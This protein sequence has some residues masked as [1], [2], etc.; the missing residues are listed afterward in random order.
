MQQVL[1]TIRLGSIELP[2]Y[3]YGTMLFITFVATLWLKRRL[4]LREG[5]PPHVSERLALWIFVTGILGARATF[6]IQYHDRFASI[7]QIVAIWDGGLVFYGS[8]FGALI[9]YM[10]ARATWLAKYNVS[11]WKMADVIAPCGALG[12]ALGR[13]GCL[14]NGCCYGNVACP[15]CAE[16]T[17]PMAAFPRQ[18]MTARGY[19]TAAGF[20]V[21]PQNGKPYVDKV[22]AGSAAEGVVESGD[23]IVSVMLREPYP[24]EDY[25]DLDFAFTGKW[26]RGLNDV[27]MS[28]ERGGK[29]VD[30]PAFAPRT[31]GLHPT[32]IYETISMS[33]MTFLLLSYY[34]YK[35]RDGLIMVVF[36]LGYAVH[37]FL[38]EMLRT[39]TDPVAFGMTLSQN[40]SI[41]IFV[42]G[43][44]LGALALYRRPGPPLAA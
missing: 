17:F 30:L 14:L 22:V 29:T 18:E 9:G 24:T 33:L 32:Q 40:I 21:V 39:D 42:S 10:I 43:L 31:I 1:F 13:I 28:V 44:M 38:N 16:I 8:V 34:P 11:T 35:R 41:L 36:M 20:T 27:Q 23:R 19:Q 12:L 26:P 5:I 4:G 15:N 37:R 3:G 7:G 6:V 2:V 25:K